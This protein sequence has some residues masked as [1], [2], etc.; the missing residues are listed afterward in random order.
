MKIIMRSN[1]KLKDILA[2][3]KL[4]YSKVNPVQ[5][6]KDCGCGA[7]LHA[8]IKLIFKGE[9]FSSTNTYDCSSMCDCIVFKDEPLTV[10]L[11]E[12]KNTN[13]LK[14]SKIEKKFCNT[15]KI[16][17]DMLDHNDQKNINIRTILLSK[18]Y[19][20]SEMELLR[21]TRFPFNSRKNKIQLELKKC[22]CELQ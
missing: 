18:G 12:L 14:T 11:V 4:T 15:L 10:Y 21:R 16:L 5:S 2:R 20:Y 22:N 13:H 17:C 19:N 1:Q 8:K 7:R 3:T 6:C 9:N